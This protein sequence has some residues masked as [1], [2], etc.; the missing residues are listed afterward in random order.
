VQIMRKISPLF[1]R[2]RAP[3]AQFGSALGQV[4]WTV[5]DQGLLGLSNFGANLVLA[6]WLTPSEFGG[7]A[8]ARSVFAICTSAHV[9]L[10]TEPTMV[11]GPGRFRDRLLSYFAALTVLHWCVSAMISA[12]VGCIGVIL[13][14]WVSAV[15]GLSMIGYALGAPVILLLWL[16]RRIFYVQS[17]PRLAG[18]ASTI[19]TAGMLAIMYMLYRWAALSSFSAPLATAGASAL[20]VCSIIVRRGFRL[21]SP[22]RNQ[23]VLEVARAHWRYGRWAVVTGILVSVPGSL[24]YLV[25]PLLVGL[26]AN[27]A[28]SAMFVLIMPAAQTSTAL[29]FLLV[30]TFARMRGHGNAAPFIWK[31]FGALVMAGAVYALLIGQFGRPLMDLL[32]QGRYTRYANLAC[33]IGLVVPPMAAISVLGSALRAYER[34]DRIFWAYVLSTAVTCI[35]GVPAVA[36]WG[37]L[38]AILGLLAGYSTTTLVMAW[39]VVRTPMGLET[40]SREP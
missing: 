30:P 19:Y 2:V 12:G 5:V 13:T 6:R 29:T 28:L 14:L 1:G 35:F 22:W 24:Y 9:G 18:F 37:L 31:T 16:F 10:L 25:V 26:D 7:Y 33:L 3:A 17:V 23:F 20:A 21:W 36:I 8:A 34:P 27:G 38:G 4:F 39:W 40:D 15:S 11:Y 32:Y